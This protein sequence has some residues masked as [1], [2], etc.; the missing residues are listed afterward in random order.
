[1]DGNPSIEP[2]HHIVVPRCYREQVLKIAHEN[3]FSGHVGYRNTLAK[4]CN[5]LY[6]P[7]I[8]KD[9]K[10]HCFSCEVCQRLD[11]LS[12][13]TKA[14]ME[15]IP[16]MGVPFHSLQMDCLGPLPASSGKKY[17]V[18][19]TCPSSKWVEAMPTSSISARKISQAL[20]EITSRM[21]LPKVLISAQAPSFTSELL[22]KL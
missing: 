17:I 13:I 11:Y 21:G 4:I 18:C 8:S 22:E 12:D 16:I 5:H 9:V 15:E 19:F 10:S 20:L 14:K 6:W 3:P 1:M 7:G 2:Q